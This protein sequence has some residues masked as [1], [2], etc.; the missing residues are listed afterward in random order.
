MSIL[1]GLKSLREE[2]LCSFHMP[3]HKGRTK[4]P[5][6]MSDIGQ[7]DITEIPGSDNLHKAQGMIKEAQEKAAKIFGAERTYFLINGTTGGILSMI[8]SQCKPKDKVLVPRNCHRAVWNG[9]ILG[10]IE[11]VYIQ[12]RVHPQ[13]GIGLSI[14]T[15]DVEGKLRDHPDIRAAIITYP[16][17][18]GTCSDLKKIGDLLHSENKLLLVDEAHGAHFAFHNDLP[19]TALEAGSDIVAQ[20]SHKMLSSFTQSSM[21]HIGN[22][23]NCSLGQLEIFL[24]LLQSTSPS[25]PLM[26]SLEFAALEAEREGYRKW[27]DILQWNQRAVEKITRETSFRILGKDLIGKYGVVDYDFSRFLI[28]VSPLGL[29]GMEVDRLLRKNFGIQVELSDYY[30]ILAM[31]GMGTEEDDIERFTRGLIEIYNQYKGLGRKN[32]YL[33]LP[34]IKEKVVLSPREAIYSPEEKVIFEE[35]MGRI[36]KEFIIPYPPGIPIILPG[37]MISQDIID[38]VNHIKSWGGE[39]I[40]S[41]DKHLNTIN[42]IA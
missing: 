7:I 13:T 11:P 35:A 28:D 16:T 22:A 4:F 29:S 23:R 2:N 34:L 38:R 25:Y 24:G 36:S 30:H 10:D 5:E 18:Y 33:Q 37:E 20:S 21:L 32:E 42:V 15:E 9:L 31:T 1:K 6:I 12:P 39:I 3:G 40:G 27:A 17:F 14:S 26:A 19:L 8:L 41:Q